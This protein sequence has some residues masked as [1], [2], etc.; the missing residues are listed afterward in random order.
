MNETSA[1]SRLLKEKAKEFIEQKKVFRI[2]NVSR[3]EDEAFCNVLTSRNELDMQK[4]GTVVTFTPKTCR[5]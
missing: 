5:A 2:Y 4:D 1:R 3:S